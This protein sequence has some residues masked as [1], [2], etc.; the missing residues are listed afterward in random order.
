MKKIV[1]NKTHGVP[2][3][4]APGLDRQELIDLNDRLVLELGKLDALAEL[5]QFSTRHRHPGGEHRRVD[6]QGGRLSDAGDSE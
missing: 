3:V 2:A 5:L 1:G 4:E 6:A